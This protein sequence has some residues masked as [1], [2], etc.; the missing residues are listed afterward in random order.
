M[1]LAALSAANGGG[2]GHSYSDFSGGVSYEGAGR[3]DLAGVGERRW[4]FF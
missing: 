3:A 2:G 1:E 4:F